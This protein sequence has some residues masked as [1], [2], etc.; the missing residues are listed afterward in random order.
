MSRSRAASL[1]SL[2]GRTASPRLLK[3]PKKSTFKN[4]PR[5]NSISTRIKSTISLK[6]KN[7]S[8]STISL[9]R[10]RKR[11]RERPSILRSRKRKRSKRRES[12]S[13]RRSSVTSRSTLAG[14]LT[15]KKN[16]RNSMIK[17][18]MIRSPSSRTFLTARRDYVTAV[19]RIKSTGDTTV[20]K[21]T[22]S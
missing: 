22:T 4:R 6:R 7:K 16:N 1:P 5:C 10:K 19:M 14:M 11:S 15:L 9:K 8:R 20:P 21:R 2:I 18:I 12:P 3:T 13:K 17:T